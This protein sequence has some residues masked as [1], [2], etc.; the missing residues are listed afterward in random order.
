VAPVLTSGRHRSGRGTDASGEGPMLG[1]RAGGR[2]SL[3]FEKAR[4]AGENMRETMMEG[5]GGDLR[6]GW[7]QGKSHAWA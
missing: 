7:Q 1:P 3:G 4:G 6:L 2:G 5:P